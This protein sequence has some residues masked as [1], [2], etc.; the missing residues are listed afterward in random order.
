M[1]TEPRAQKFRNAENL[2]FSSL[3]VK[4]V[5]PLS[6]VSQ[7]FFPSS[8]QKLKKSSA[9]TEFQDEFFHIIDP[10]PRPHYTV[11]HSPLWNLFWHCH[12]LFFT[13]LTQLLFLLIQTTL[14]F[15]GLRPSFTDLCSPSKSHGVYYT[16]K[17]KI[18]PNLS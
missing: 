4:L 2:T 7:I 17:R 9:I 14:F 8:W 10:L 15:K 3:Q 1:L 11:S 6:L 13:S 5:T 12:G 16:H 18:I